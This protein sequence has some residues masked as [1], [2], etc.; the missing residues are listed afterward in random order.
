MGPHLH[1][2]V[3][4][5]AVR[6][7]HLKGRDEDVTLADGDVRRVTALP[8]TRGVLDP[9][10]VVPLPFGIRH[11]T[12][13]LS[14]QIDAGRRADAPATEHLLNALGMVGVVKRL[15]NLVEHGVAGIGDAL[16]EIHPAVS[17]VVPA[18]HAVLLA[19][20]RPIARALDE[21]ACRGHAR[22]KR[23]ARRERLDGG[24]RGVQAV[25][26]TVKK[27]GVCALCDE[28]RPGIGADAADERG[29]VERRVACHGKDLAGLAVDADTRCARGLVV[30]VVACL[31]AEK[32]RLLCGSLHRCIHREPHVASRL[33]IDFR[34]YPQDVARDVDV[35]LARTA[36]ALQH[37]FIL[38]FD[39]RLAHDVA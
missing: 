8:G 26:G 7:A 32:Q 1:R 22:L 35:D 31:E 3:H 6:I 12:L 16:I 19:K 5:A 24:G 10:V 36:H 15:R 38:V 17:G 34:S 9:S 33:G 14:R 39:A 37:V 29:G 20:T 28:L 13:R 4:K 30:K 25:D 2:P 18:M 27:R 23:G 21:G 11:A